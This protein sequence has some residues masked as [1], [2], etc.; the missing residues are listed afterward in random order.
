MTDIFKSYNK[1]L[2]EL[3]DIISN[4][5][6]HEPTIHE[7]KRKYTAAVTTDR[8]LLLTETGKELFIFREFI[9]ENRWDELINMDL[10]ERVVVDI[11]KK[12]IEHMIGLLRKIWDNYDSDEKKYVKKLIKRLLSDYTK[13]R[14]TQ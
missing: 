7:V 10:S 3:I 8:T 12:T 6:P 1:T 13:Y 5:L 4:E 14:M 9:A 11:D 2:K